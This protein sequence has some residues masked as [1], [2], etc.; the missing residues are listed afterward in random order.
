MDLKAIATMNERNDQS[1]RYW[2]PYNLMVQEFKLRADCVPLSA[3]AVN[4]L[5]SH[6][7]GLLADLFMPSELPGFEPAPLDVGLDDQNRS[8][9]P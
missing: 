6:A 1:Y 3:A 5:V 8:S 2:T 4:R 9:H 7:R